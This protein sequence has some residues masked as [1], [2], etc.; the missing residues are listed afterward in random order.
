M[1]SKKERKKY[2][3]VNGTDIDDMI[4]ARRIRPQS[5]KPNR[6]PPSRRCED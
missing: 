2:I 4:I 5:S 3:Y 6:P 1:G